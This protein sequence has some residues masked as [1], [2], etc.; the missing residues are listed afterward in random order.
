[1]PTSCAAYGC[2]N[3]RTKD[4]GVSFHRFP[5]NKE[6]R[7]AWIRHVRRADFIPSLYTFLCSNHFEA[8]CFD[9]TGQTVRLR[10]D[11]VPTIFDFPGQKHKKASSPRETATSRKA[12]APIS[13]PLEQP[14][15]P[16]NV[17]EDHSYCLVS[18]SA[19]KEKI[20]D[21]KEQLEAARKKLKASQQR[22]RR[23]GM[24][25]AEMRD[26]MTCL[27][28]KKLVP[29]GLASDVID[30]TL[31]GMDLKALKKEMRIQSRTLHRRYYSFESRH[32]CLTLHLHAPEAYK[33]VEQHLDLPHPSVLREWADVSAG[34]PFKEEL[35][36][37][38][39]GY[40]LQDTEFY[41]RINGGTVQADLD[42]DS[43]NEEDFELGDPLGG[44]PKDS[45][46]SEALVF[47]LVTVNGNLKL[48]LAYSLSNNL[49]GDALKDLVH[50]CLAKLYDF[51]VC[52]REVTFD[53]I[54]TNIFNSKVA[55][56]ELYSL[57][58]NFILSHAA[59]SAL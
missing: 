40:S 14:A 25:W 32:F 29:S 9:R 54:S 53:D 1:M 6:R 8:S 35:F 13:T 34:H 3:I 51:G 31:G 27:K 18:L 17:Y 22:E 15:Q 10:E 55:K 33:Y 42:W 36:K 16:V 11:A 41:L 37:W 49:S 47:L 48:P 30:S 44:T 4:C 56:D 21:L 2:T 46:A 43:S 57:L 19:A 5:L 58:F 45:A 7:T 50:Q 23:L 12:L 38:L 20:S 39:S 59:E 28:R 52:I 24:R 26:L